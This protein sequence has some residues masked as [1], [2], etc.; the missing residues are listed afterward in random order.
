MRLLLLLPPPPA[1]AVVGRR[2]RRRRTDHRR[3]QQKSESDDV[4]TRSRPIVVKKDAFSSRDVLRRLG[5]L[6]R[7]CVENKTRETPAPT[8]EAIGKR[9]SE[10]CFLLVVFLLLRSVLS[11]L[12]DVAMMQKS[13]RARVG[14][15]SFSLKHI[16]TNISL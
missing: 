15:C 9:F 10:V 8:S 13:A 3:A 4:V 14:S 2:Q 1:I 16:S 11:R 7:D 5:K 12:L 6:K